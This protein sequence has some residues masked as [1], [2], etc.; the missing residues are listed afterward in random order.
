MLQVEVDNLRKRLEHLQHDNDSLKQ[1]V[2][3]NH[4]AHAKEL[5]D[6][7]AVKRTCIATQKQKN[8]PSARSATGW[9]RLVRPS[10][11]PTSPNKK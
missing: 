6:Q 2:Q 9:T 10:I 4:M 5:E 8:W 1:R 3:V 11:L 7:L